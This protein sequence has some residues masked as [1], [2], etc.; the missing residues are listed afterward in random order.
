MATTSFKCSPQGIHWIAILATCEGVAIGIVVSVASVSMIPSPREAS[1][2]S[3]MFSVWRASAKWTMIAGA[4][5]IT[6]ASR[7]LN[8][9]NR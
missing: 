3:I 4:Q 8:W 1:A 6:F 5:G 7:F 2:G 9:C